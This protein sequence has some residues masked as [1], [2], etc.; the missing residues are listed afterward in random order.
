MQYCGCIYIPIYFMKKVETKNEAQKENLTVECWNFNQVLATSSGNIRTN[1]ELEDDSV[2]GPGGDTSYGED[3][4][5]MVSNSQ[6]LPN[7]ARDKYLRYRTRVFA[8]EYANPI[9][10]K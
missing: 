7:S 10:F 3:D 1:K 6:G 5:N 2:S 4:E 8:S 9:L